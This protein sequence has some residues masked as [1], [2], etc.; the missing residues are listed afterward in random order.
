VFADTE[1]SVKLLVVVV[2]G[3]SFHVLPLSSERAIL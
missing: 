1:V 2:V 3:R